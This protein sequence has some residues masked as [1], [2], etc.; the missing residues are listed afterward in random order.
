MVGL[1]VTDEMRSS[2]KET[3]VIYFNCYLS[4]CLRELMKTAK[5]SVRIASLQSK[6][7]SQDIPN[8]KLVCYILG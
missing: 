6:I 2:P 7:R 3:G 4:I 1:F 5:T 8:T